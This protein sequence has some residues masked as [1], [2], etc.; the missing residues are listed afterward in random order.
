V[1]ADNL[2]KHCMDLDLLLQDGDSRD[3]N[4]MDLHHE[5]RIFCQIVD[6]SYTTPIQCFQFLHKTRDSFPN[7]V[8]AQRIMLTMPITIATAERSFSKLKIIKKLRED[9][10]GSRKTFQFGTVI[11]RKRVM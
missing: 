1:T 10:E 2:K 6:S 9:N 7:L 5:I 11:Y 4:G 8:I 3:I